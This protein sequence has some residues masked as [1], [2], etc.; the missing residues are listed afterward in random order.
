MCCAA[1]QALVEAVRSAFLAGRVIVCLRR[2]CMGGATNLDLQKGS[3]VGNWSTI[4]ATPTNGFVGAVTLSAAITSSPTGAQYPPT[5]SFGSTSPV[6]LV[7]F[8]EASARMTITSTP[9]TSG[10]VNYP[11]PPGARW[12]ARGGLALA[13]VLIF[14]APLKRRRL[15]ALGMLAMLAVLGSALSCGGGSSTTTGGGGG[16]GSSGTTS[17][18]Y[19]ITITG[20]SGTMTANTIMTL[21]VH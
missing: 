2:L 19:T 1:E 20:T 14:F 7:N 11:V 17:G 8:T 15:K 16:G 4:T 9:A 12:Y 18:Q 5:L 13:C 6:N 10:A 3:T 21:T